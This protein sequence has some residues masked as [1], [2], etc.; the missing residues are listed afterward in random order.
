MAA[1]GRI[2]DLWREQRLFEQ[3]AIAAVVVVGLLAGGRFQ[4][5]DGE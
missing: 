4:L 1:P 5:L 3:R 2:K